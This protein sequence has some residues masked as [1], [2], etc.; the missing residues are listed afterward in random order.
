M[1]PTLT[2]Y[3]EIIDDS[4]TTRERRFDFVIDVGCDIL[5]V[6]GFSSKVLGYGR[7]EIRH[8]NLSMLIHPESEILLTEITYCVA[9]QQPLETMILFLNGTQH[10]VV[11]CTVMGQ[12]VTN[13][14]DHFLLRFEWDPDLELKSR[15]KHSAEGLVDDVHRLLEQHQEKD[16]NL[17]FVDIG[18]V[19]SAV[20]SLGLTDEEAG[21]FQRQ[22]EDRL[23]RDSIDGKTVNRVDSG[24]YGLVAERSLDVGA[25][26]GDLQSYAGR[27]DPTGA[28]L[29]VGTTQIALDSEGMS[30]EDI[31]QAVGHAIHEFVDSGLDAIIFDTLADSQAAWV[32][33]RANRTAL[34]QQVV[35]NDQLSVVYRPTLDPESWQIDHLLAEFRADLED[36]GLGVEEIISLTAE[37]PD[38]RS[39]VDMAQCRFIVD[40]V[41]LDSTG[42]AI[43]LSIR[44]LLT[45]G[46]ME[47]LVEFAHYY[48][49]R[50]VILRLEGLTADQVGRISAIQVLRKAGFSI[51][52]IGRE[53]GAI[54]EEV[55]KTLPADYIILDSSFAIDA[56][57]LKRSLPALGS[58][59]KRCADHGIKTLFEGVTD[60]SS[61]RLLAAVPGSL[62]MGDYLGPPVTSPDQLSL[63]RN[64]EG[65]EEA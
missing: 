38:L 40:S 30:H 43:S 5:G 1:P 21:D 19:D 32:D 56:D 41:G 12:P 64:Q 14:K 27:L 58:M 25:L 33:K 3:G 54:S 11:G 57:H 29:S 59:A 9:M 47:G 35:E 52:L 8:Q 16:L 15:P 45:P 10:R 17:T 18:D 39:A 65:A 44:S 28:S 26:T 36:D 53:I 24:K 48:P 4:D 42:I 63:P 61:V 46:M 37:K 22:V 13:A 7:D 2:K 51:A 20:S 62:I 60:I 55:L 50:R 49:D 23:R 34:L 31:N 6:T